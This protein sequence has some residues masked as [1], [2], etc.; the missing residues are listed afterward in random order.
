MFQSMPN[1]TTAR[2][3]EPKSS[4]PA[5]KGVAPPSN[6]SFGETSFI[7]RMQNRAKT[8]EVCFRYLFPLLYGW[9]ILR[10]SQLDSDDQQQI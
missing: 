10:L 9:F 4:T 8:D 6:E 7:A 5:K 3:D 2:F 1:R